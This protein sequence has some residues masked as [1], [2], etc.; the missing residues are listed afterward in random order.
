MGKIFQGE[1]EQV[2]IFSIAHLLFENESKLIVHYSL[3]SKG[4]R[5]SLPLEKGCELDQELE[6]LALIR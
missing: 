3:N 2:N 1:K 4:F 6:L 5:F